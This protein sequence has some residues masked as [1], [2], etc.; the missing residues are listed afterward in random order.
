MIRRVLIPR[1]VQGD[2][3]WN[4]RALRW[5]GNE[6]ELRAFDRV[7]AS[8]SRPALITQLS[9]NS[10]V[11]RRSNQSQPANLSQQSSLSGVRIVGD[12]VFDPVRMSWYSR[13]EEGDEELDFGDDEADVHWSTGGDTIKL[14]AKASFLNASEVTPG[15]TATSSLSGSG[16]S[17]AGEDEFVK[18]CRVAEQR[19][20][21]EMSHWP[22]VS[23]TEPIDRSYLWSIRKV[24]FRL[25][26]T[27]L[28]VDL[29]GFGRL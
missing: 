8:S 22:A 26:M 25:T 7:M 3:T 29:N 5:E 12:M 14:K 16:M 15:S 1:A 21:A 23:S 13:A 10:P 9:S 27:E 20:R 2:M 6:A 18:A 4:P 28:H 11:M 19:H 17:H 24:R